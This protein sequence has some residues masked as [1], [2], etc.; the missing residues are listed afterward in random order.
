M[1]SKGIALQ[2]ES[3]L[4]KKKKTQSTKVE[5]N[6][7]KIDAIGTNLRRTY[8]KLFSYRMKEK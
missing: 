2:G 3:A 5:R 1:D 7:T 8:C 6:S 4:T